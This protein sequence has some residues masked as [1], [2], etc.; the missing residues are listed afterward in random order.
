MTVRTYV[1]ATTRAQ[2]EA[3]WRLFESTYPNIA[4]FKLGTPTS[5]IHYRAF[6]AG[7]RWRIGDY[8]GGEWKGMFVG[9]ERDGYTHT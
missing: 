5:R 4:R 9:I 2:R 6:R 8:I 1:K 3:V 7:F